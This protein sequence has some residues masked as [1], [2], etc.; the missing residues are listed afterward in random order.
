MYGMHATNLAAVDL[1]L[2]VALDALLTERS[3]TRAAH[4][5]GLSQPAASHALARLRDLLGDPVLV[6]SGAR[7][8][9]TP[10]AEALASPV[11]AI[12]DDVRRTLAP[13]G[14][15]PA[16]SR[17]AFTLGC[18]DYG[19]LVIVP[20]L[21]RRLSREA[22]GIDL[23]VRPA[24]DDPS[25]ALA[26]GSVDVAVGVS[27]VR[28]PAGSV[29]RRRLFDDGFACLVRGDHPEVGNSLTLARFLALG[30]AF[31]AP[32]GTRGGVVDDALARRGLTRRVV[33]MVPSFAATPAIVAGTDLVV[34]LPAR[35]GALLAEPFGLRALSPPLPLPRFTVSAL[36]HERT[37]RD[38]AAE[39]FRG[40]LAEVARS[41]DAPHHRAS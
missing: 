32:R 37:H 12:L 19:E 30:H 39:W 29:R 22:P 4:R 33:A 5:L 15:E 13:E 35:L 18:A 36:W 9:A 26:S 31:I 7:L 38:P 27:L 28:A 23:V 24:P 41:L 21:L 25:A 20:Q 17:R 10:R 8:V 14:F 2:L 40:V 11:R 6:R 1:N 16:S 34:T 3:V